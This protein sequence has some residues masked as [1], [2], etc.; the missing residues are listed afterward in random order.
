MMPQKKIIEQTIFYFSHEEV[1]ELLVA[2]IQYPLPL[3]LKQ[4]D[5]KQISAGLG[6]GSGLTLCLQ[7]EVEEKSDA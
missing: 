3:N 4:Y 1:E 5:S 2:A 6:V 7:R